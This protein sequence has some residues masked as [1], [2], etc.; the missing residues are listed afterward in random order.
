MLILTEGPSEVEYFNMF[1]GTNRQ[2]AIVPIATKRHG[3]NNLVPY[4]YS[5]A[6]ERNIDLKNGDTVSIVIDKDDHEI[7]ELEE[8]E[9]QCKTNNYDLYLSNRSFECWLLMHFRDLTKPM[10]QNELEDA[11]SKCIGVKYRKSEGIR[12]CFNE[13]YLKSALTRANKRI[14]NENERNSICVK[15]DPSTTIHFLMNKLMA[16]EKKEN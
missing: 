6:V 10:S 14:P 11:L 7:S 12:R 16:G 9:K 5:K 15:N 4:C 2:V 3:S 1:K 13:K 8:I